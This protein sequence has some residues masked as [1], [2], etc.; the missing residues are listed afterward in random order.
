MGDN[1]DKVEFQILAKDTLGNVCQETVT[2]SCSLVLTKDT[3]FPDAKLSVKAT[4]GNETKSYSP[5]NYYFNASPGANLKLHF[6]LTDSTGIADFSDTLP[7]VTFKKNDN[8]R[9]QLY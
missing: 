5:E 4:V 6:E 9:E 8:C 2:D 7:S 1:G 3:Q